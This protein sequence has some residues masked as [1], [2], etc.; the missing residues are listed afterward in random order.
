MEYFGYFQ[1]CFFNDNDNKLDL[2]TL[3]TLPEGAGNVTY[4][5]ISGSG[6][7]DGSILNIELQGTERIKVTVAETENHSADEF[8]I[9]VTVEAP[10]GSGSFD[11]EWVPIG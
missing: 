1:N 10:K 6:T 5:L 7:L 9:T 11:G 8:E 4:E 2:S 3:F